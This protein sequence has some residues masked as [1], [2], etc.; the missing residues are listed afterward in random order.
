MERLLILLLLLLFFMIYKLD[1]KR[2][3]TPAC[4]SVLAFMI[5][6]L[7]FA[8][9]AEKWETEIRIETVW[10]IFTALLVFWIGSKAKF[11]IKFAGSKRDEN[12]QDNVY[13][14]VKPIIIIA[15]FLAG[16]VVDFVIY[17]RAMQIISNYAAGKFALYTLRNALAKDASWGTI[18]SILR[19]GYYA[20]GYSCLFVYCVNISYAPKTS[21]KKWLYVLLPVI[22]M[23]IAMFMS[24][25]R[26]GFIRVT[27]VLFIS[28]IT[29]INYSKRV[30]IGKL[31]RNGILVFAALLYV[32]FQLGKATGK[33]QIFSAFDTLSIYV[34]SSIGAL[35][36]Y[37]KNP[38]SF[39]NSFAGET[40]YGLRK[41]ARIFNERIVAT[42][43]PLPFHYVVHGYN[44]NVYTALR[45]YIN[46]FGIVGMYGIMAMKGM[47]FG[48]WEQSLR[49]KKNRGLSLLL[50]A[51]FMYDIV[52]QSIEENFLRELFTV[53][54]I[55]IMIV[56]FLLY[57]YVLMPSRTYGPAEKE[58]LRN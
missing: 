34:G 52:M 54:Q 16:M 50:Y 22:P 44:T 8:I 42:P 56:F 26:T 27:C 13:Y 39:S 36:G 58:E 51:Y 4:L 57:Y 9:N 3:T 2:I 55:F 15:L 37:L 6:A 48:H 29:L 11:K 19:E 7:V 35:D 10:L 17:R 30:K 45:R 20:V 25:G 49:E 32:F 53:A 12:L 14:D 47:I 40:L 5:S 31:A 46:D 23:L 1:G 28:L 24:T 43:I 41:I 21:W 18:I 33:S 38:V